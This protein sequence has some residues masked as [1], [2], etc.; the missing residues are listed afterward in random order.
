MDDYLYTT[1]GA[2]G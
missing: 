2:D 1:L